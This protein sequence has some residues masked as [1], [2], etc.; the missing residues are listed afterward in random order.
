MQNE[1]SILSQWRLVRNQLLAQWRRLS[2]KELEETGPDGHRIAQLVASKY[3]ISS[4]MVE[5]YLHS[6]AETIPLKMKRA[7]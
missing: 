4:E 1:D 3:N 2:M 7:A 5:S 6:F